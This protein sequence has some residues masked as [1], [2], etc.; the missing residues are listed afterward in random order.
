MTRH[1][2]VFAV[3][4]PLWLRADIYFADPAFPKAENVPLSLKKESRKD[5]AEPRSSGFP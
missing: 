5:L 3:G 4:I 2:L 1:R